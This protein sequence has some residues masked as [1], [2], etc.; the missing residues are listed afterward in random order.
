MKNKSKNIIIA[1]GGTGGHLFPALAIADEIIKHKN[2]NVIFLAQDM[3]LNQTS[4][5]NIQ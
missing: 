3:G 1:G 2:Y 5:V 4:L